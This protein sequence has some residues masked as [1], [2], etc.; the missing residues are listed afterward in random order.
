MFTH[1]FKPSPPVRP[2]LPWLR[3]WAWNWASIALAGLAVGVLVA[4]FYNQASVSQ[5]D[6]PKP[7]VTHA[8]P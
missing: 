8:A 3:H 6:Y 4:G 7:Q 1:W 2:L 5:F